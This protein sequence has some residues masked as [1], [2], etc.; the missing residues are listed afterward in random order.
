MAVTYANQAAFVAALAKLVPDMK[1]G[2][3]EADFIQEAVNRLSEDVPGYAT[4]DVGDGSTYEWALGTSPFASWVVGFSE[5]WP[6]QVEQLNAAGAPYRPP[7]PFSGD[8]PYFDE[9]TSGG[10]PTLYLVFVTAPGST[11]KAR[12][13][14][15]IPWTIGVSTYT[16]PA[17]FHVAVVKLAAALKCSA[18][19]TYYKQT[20]DPAGG[21]DI[22]DAR[23]YAE[24]YASD[25]ERFLAEY[26][27]AVPPVSS[28]AGLAFGRV[29]TALPTIFP[30]WGGR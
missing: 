6:I 24:S 10:V 20:I 26:R 13:R 9:R 1:G 11:A 5:A 29:S 7:A 23:Q 30:A 14:F 18:L 19:S 3:T 28:S 4:A 22:F 21:S 16:V 25:A 8:A 12:I 17:A 15:R 2:Y 27:A